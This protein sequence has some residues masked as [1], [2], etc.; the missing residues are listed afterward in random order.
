MRR[1]EQ[2]EAR[3]YDQA[4][5]ASLAGEIYKRMRESES[6]RYTIGAMQP[7][8]PDYTKNTIEQGERVKNQLKERLSIEC[9]YEF[10]G[11]T[12]T[13]TH[14]KARSDIDLLLIRQGW[15]WVEGASVSPY[16]GDARED[17][18]RLRREATVAMTAAFPQ[19]QLDDTGSTSFKLSGASLSRVVDVVP[20]S[21]YNTS[22]Y[23]RTSDK[24]HRG[25]KVFNKNTGEFIPN[26]PFLHKRRIEERDQRTRG[27]LRRAVRL[28]KSLRYDS[29]GRAD[30]SSYNIAGIAY[31]IPELGLLHE[32]AR[33]LA[34][35]EACWE[36]CQRLSFDLALRDSIR[37][38]DGSRTVFGGGQGATGI[39]LAALTK[40]LSDLRRDVLTENARSFTKLLEA[41]IAHPLESAPRW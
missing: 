21:W 28:M 25:V 18:R 34:I 2:L 33:E 29:D 3:R 14:I 27:G 17:M 23:T 1:L 8:D 5:K 16:S 30:M 32:P 11:S 13:D 31:N 22:D 24:T 15:Y 37:V 6:V 4:V 39:Q 9:D 38:P 26:T 40:E 10:Q 36:Y 7:I 20:A 41:R 35:L 12:M 19:A